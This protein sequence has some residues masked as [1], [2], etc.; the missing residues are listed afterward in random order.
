MHKG[1]LIRGSYGKKR[2][3]KGK[4]NQSGRKVFFEHGY[5]ET[6]VRMIQEEANVVTGSFYH[7][8]PSKELLF[9]VVVERFLAGYTEKD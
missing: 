8:F 6:S 4:D 3:N 2:R 1:K 9:E 5:E 7:F